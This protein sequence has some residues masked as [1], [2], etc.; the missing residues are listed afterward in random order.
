MYDFNTPKEVGSKENKKYFLNLKSQQYEQLRNGQNLFKK[1]YSIIE[2]EKMNQ[3]ICIQIIEELLKAKEDFIK[4]IEIET[5]IEYVLQMNNLQDSNEIL[6][7]LVF[8]WDIEE[9]PDQFEKYKRIL[10]QRSPFCELIL[11]LKEGTVHTF[12]ELFAHY[13]D[14]MKILYKGYPHLHQ[15]I[16]QKDRKYLL[17]HKIFSIKYRSFAN[18]YFIINEIP[19]N[20]KLLDLHDDIIFTILSAKQKH[21]QDQIMKSSNTK[22]LDKILKTVDYQEVIFLLFARSQEKQE[23]LLEQ[24]LR[25]PENIVNDLLQKLCSIYEMET[26]YTEKMLLMVN[27]TIVIKL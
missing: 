15:I 11:N 2:D 14:K 18:K 3:E 25:K 23:N 5:S 6:K 13:L 21:I 17:N 7:L 19:E 12:K 24:M 9:K 1:L 22:E 20:P 4:D 26:F 10:S 27:I 8:Y 16:L